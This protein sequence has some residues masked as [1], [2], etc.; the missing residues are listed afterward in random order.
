MARLITIESPETLP[1]RLEVQ[2]GDLLVVE[3]CGAHQ[4]DGEAVATLLGVF[5][6]SVVGLHHEVLT[7]AGPPNAVAILARAPGVARFELV[8]GDPWRAVRRV[9]F[10]LIVSPAP[11]PVERPP[12]APDLPLSSG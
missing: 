12:E 10:A 9:P 11:S 8:T 2:P 6:S 4:R 7:P 1:P 5:L 3:A